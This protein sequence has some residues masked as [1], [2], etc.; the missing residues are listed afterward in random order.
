MPKPNAYFWKCR[1]VFLTG[2]TGFKGS[3]LSL[4]L[5][6]LG[7]ELTGYAL[8]PP[9]KPS[10]FEIAKVGDGMRAIS[11]DICDQKALENALEVAS[12]EIVIH[13]AAQPLVRRS[14]SDPSET[15]RTNIMGTVSLFEAIRKTPSVR[16]VINVT[17]DKC[18]ENR[19]WI[20][21][22]RE[23]D[24]LGGYDPYSSSKACSEL[25]TTAYRN[26][27]FNPKTPLSKKVFIASARAGNIIG[28][29]DWATDRLVPDI[30]AAF[31]REQPAILRYPEARRPW[32]H[33]LEPLCGYLLLAER[34][35]ENNDK[36]FGA[37]NFG[38]QDQ[39]VESV[40][41]LADLMVKLWHKPASWQIDKEQVAYEATILKLDTSKARHE[42]GWQTHIRLKD[43]LIMT[44]D[45]IRAYQNKSDMRQFTQQQIAAYE[46]LVDG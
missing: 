15:Y 38:P 39:D 2:N 13:M 7:A 43:A 12:P 3:W 24:S 46:N 31:T 37:W 11:G 27:F 35:F 9:T 34:L 5:Q 1:R 17:T 40:A 25:I 32:Q 19:E 28:G 8:P 16:A 21:G 22:Y 36:F 41:Q 30:I 10:L 18:Y 26:S 23:N 20:W 14:Y 29:G 44:I 4:W 45:W 42:L 33:V 6:R